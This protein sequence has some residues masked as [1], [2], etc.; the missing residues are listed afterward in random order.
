MTYI[1]LKKMKF[2]VYI[3]IYIYIYVYIYIY[4]YIYIRVSHKIGTSH[5]GGGEWIKGNKKFYFEILY[6]FRIRKGNV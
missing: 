2:I 6:N 4:I 1:Y 5:I 3:Y